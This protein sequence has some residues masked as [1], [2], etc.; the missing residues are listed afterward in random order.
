MRL[1]SL[2]PALLLLVPFPAALR[3]AQAPPV[4]QVTR[5]LDDLFRSKSSLAEVELVSR[6][7]TQD[8]RL[9]LRM[10]T[11]GQDRSL[12]I[13]DE[14]ERDAGTA[15]LRVGNNLWNYLPKIARTIR[16]PPSMMLASWMGTD[17][18]NDDLVKD[19]S[20]E[21]D[22]R[23]GPGAPSRDPAGWLYTGVARAGVVGRWQKIEWV[24][25][26]EGSLP[27]L[28]R[29]FDRK[30]LL[31]RTMSFSRV[32]RMGGRLLP[33]LMVLKSVDQ[34]GHVMELRYLSARFDIPLSDDTFSLSRLERR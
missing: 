20:Y 31:A 1:P 10:W 4:R 15:T 14:P 18:T 28:A 29:Y 24:V 34:P 16:V 21:H 19:S 32:E 23:F 17:F 12:I 26:A 8:R 30:G 7:D 11:K 25:D 2:L 5:M 13:I 6:T 9:K 33:T 22:F 27:L 3:A